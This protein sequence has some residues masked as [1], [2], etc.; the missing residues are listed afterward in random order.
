[1]RVKQPLQTYQVYRLSPDLGNDGLCHHRPQVAES[2]SLCFFLLPPDSCEDRDF[3]LPQIFA[4]HGVSS[5][6][7]ELL[8]G[9][10]SPTSVTWA[11][12]LGLQSPEPLSL[13]P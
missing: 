4:F 8:I 1:M 12:H 10:G 7:H 9:F 2:L 13:G 5:H 11:C 3:L 6:C